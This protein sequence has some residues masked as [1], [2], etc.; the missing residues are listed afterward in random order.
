MNQEMI[1]RWNSVVG[2]EDIVYHLGDF[3]MGQPS[4]WPA[5][6]K[7]LNG[8]RKILIRGGHDR[9]PHQML[10][11]GFSEV[12]EKLVW[13]G[14]L[15]QH[16]PMN[17]KQ[18]LLC[19]HIHDKWRRLGDIINVGVDVWDFTPRTIEELVKAEESSWEYKCRHCGVTLRRL[20]DNA[21][22]RDGKCL[23]S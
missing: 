9:K 23:T 18:K 11:V 2:P 6:L 12:H 22:H 10:E 17:T 13:N 19:G 14:W 15:L 4:E 16:E 8:A 7:Q 21:H 3:A 5:I 1:A 20:E